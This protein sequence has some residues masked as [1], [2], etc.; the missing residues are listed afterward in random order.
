MD[1]A[2]PILVIGL[3][4]SLLSDDAVGLEVAAQLR[5]RLAGRTDVVIDDDTC[6]GLRLMERMVGYRQAVVV[7]AICTG[8]EPGTIYE[9]RVGELPTAHSGSAHDMT[10]PL[11]L[12]VGRRAGAVLPEDEHIKLF[13]VEAA[14]CHTFSERCTDPVRSAVPRVVDH[15]ITL[16][17]NREF[18]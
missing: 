12:A 13:A 2:Q 1:S 11:A 8:G 6:G 5:E 9:L 10:L 18:A 14:D 3:G 4:N 15:V 7:D 16:I 17:E